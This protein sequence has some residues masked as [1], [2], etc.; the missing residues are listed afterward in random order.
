MKLN[1]WKFMLNLNNL[2]F[3]THVTSICFKFINLLESSFGQAYIAFISSTQL[4]RYL[5]QVPKHS[6][7]RQMVKISKFL[8]SV[9]G[10]H[11]SRVESASYTLSP[12]GGSGRPGYLQ[13]RGGPRP[14]PGPFT[15]QPQH[16][17]SHFASAPQPVA[18]KSSYNE[19]CMERGLSTQQHGGVKMGGYMSTAENTAANLSLAGTRFKM[20]SPPPQVTNTSAHRVSSNCL[21]S[22]H[23]PGHTR[24][25]F[26]IRFVSSWLAFYASSS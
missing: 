14:R 8:F 6:I 23:S 13:E 24:S 10:M 25:L 20:P 2:W 11:Q 5:L 12:R 7:N 22:Q 26:S 9:A 1:Y 19:Q 4:S 15:P 21:I 3:Q 18:D 16:G 17:Y